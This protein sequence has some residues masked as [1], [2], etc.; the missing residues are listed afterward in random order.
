MGPFG[1][2]PNDLYWPVYRTPAVIAFNSAAVSREQAPQDWDDVLEPAWDDKV[3]IRDPVASGTMRAIWGLILQ[4]SIRTTGDTAA[5]WEWLRR[6]DGHTKTYALNPAI[7]DEDVRKASSRSGTSLT[8]SSG[9]PRACRSTTC[10]LKAA[11][12]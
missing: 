10:S 12:W 8:S 11:P 7:L 1:I 6:L 3:L 4:R 9:A 5:G 2:G